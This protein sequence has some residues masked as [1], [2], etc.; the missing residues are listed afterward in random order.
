[1]N[2]LTVVFESD[3]GIATVTEL[4]AALIRFARVSFEGHT[5]SQ[6]DTVTLSKAILDAQA[7]ISDASISKI[8]GAR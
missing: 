2:K 1:M 6:A 3:R 5:P 7:T 8:R 4:Q